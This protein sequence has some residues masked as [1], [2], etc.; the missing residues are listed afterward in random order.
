MKKEQ[1]ELYSELKS[2]SDSHLTKVEQLARLKASQLE[3]KPSSDAWSAIECIEHL[4]RYGDFYLPEC[5]RS[6][7]SAQPASV[8][9]VFRSSW[10]GEYFAQ[11]ML[12]KEGFKPMK[13]FKEMNPSSFDEVRLDA[14]VVFQKQ[15][16]DWLLFLKEA[17][18]YNWNKVKTGI[19]IAS[20]IHLRLGDTLRVVFYHN[21]R[22]LLQA[23]RVAKVS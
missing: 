3:A 21:E 1:N 17:Q 11:S 7:N 22:H 10:L 14:L 12:P 9:P 13:T 20:W 6:L 4:N 23:F 2:L 16:E 15:L 5:R 18:D 19:S 8:Q